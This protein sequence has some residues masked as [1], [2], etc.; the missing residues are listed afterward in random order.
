MEGIDSASRGYRD[1]VQQLIDD[2]YSAVPAV[3]AAAE[4]AARVLQTSIRSST[5]SIADTS[6]F[7]IAEGQ[8]GTCAAVN[9]SEEHERELFEAI[10]A[11]YAR[12]FNTDA[13]LAAR[14]Q[15]IAH[16]TNVT[17]LDA[18]PSA[19]APARAAQ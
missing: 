12:T 10:N 1:D 3:K 8:A 14:R 16:A 6:S 19:C 4:S 18:D 13:R 17:V 5:L 11:V 7:V 9:V 15:F 2:K